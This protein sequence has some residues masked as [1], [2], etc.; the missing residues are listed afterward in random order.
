[1]GGALWESVRCKEEGCCPCVQEDEKCG[2]LASLQALSDEKDRLDANVQHGLEESSS[3]RFQLA[4]LTQVGVV[5]MATV[6]RLP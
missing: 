4:T 3:T 6:C 2:L 1:M 5:T